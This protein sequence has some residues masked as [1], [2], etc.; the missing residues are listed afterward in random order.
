M[1]SDTVECGTADSFDFPLIFDTIYKSTWDHA[2]HTA[3]LTEDMCLLFERMVRRSVDA[4]AVI[5]TEDTTNPMENLKSLNGLNAAN[6]LDT[7]TTVGPNP[8][9]CVTQARTEKS[10]S[11]T[12]GGRTKFRTTVPPAFYDGLNTGCPAAICI[13]STT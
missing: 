7:V 1:E 2:A 4:V 3:S 11:V 10:P 6:L 9:D 12:G 5:D 13:A 8:D